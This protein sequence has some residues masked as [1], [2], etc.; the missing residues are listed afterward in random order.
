MTVDAA[1]NQFRA[2]L[3][4]TLKDVAF[5]VHAKIVH[6]TPIDTGRA[7]ASWR[8]N[9]GEADESVEPLLRDRIRQVG[10]NFFFELA[11]PKEHPLYSDQAASIARAQQQKIGDKASRIVISNNLDYIEDLE[12]GTSQQAPRG[13]V[14][15]TVHP[16]AVE[17]MVSDAVR[18]H[19]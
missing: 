11:G 18:K 5:D 3:L 7:K 12:N 1:R 19:F 17:W 4:A 13:M 8:L 6:R 10:R 15:V 14:A 9:E 16:Q 2:A